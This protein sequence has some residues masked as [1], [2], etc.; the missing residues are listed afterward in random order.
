MQLLTKIK[1]DVEIIAHPSQYD[2]LRNV[3]RVDCF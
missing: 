2:S 3:P 1:C